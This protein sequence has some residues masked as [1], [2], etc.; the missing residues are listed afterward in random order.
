VKIN[1]N[2][3]CHVVLTESGAEA[4]NA[5]SYYNEAKAAGETLRTELWSLMHIFGSEC[6]M[7]NTRQPFFENN[8]IEIVSQ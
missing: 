3:I 2:A 4:Y 5:Y 8:V 6:Y 7:G 1:I